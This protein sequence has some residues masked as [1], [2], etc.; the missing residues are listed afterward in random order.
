MVYL[1]YYSNKIIINLPP[2]IIITREPYLLLFILIY[3]T[4]PLLFS[5]SSSYFNTSLIFKRLAQAIDAIVRLQYKEDF[6]AATVA[7]FAHIMAKAQKT[8]FRSPFYPTGVANDAFAGNSGIKTYQNDS[9]YSQRSN[10]NRISICCP[11]NNA[12]GSIILAV[13]GV[14]VVIRVALNLQVKW[15]YLK[16]HDSTLGFLPWP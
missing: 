3:Y 13:A 10:D 11:K 4:T 1:H 7:S 14:A 15:G 16:E 8:S 2:F 6:F 5:S 12:R 9:S